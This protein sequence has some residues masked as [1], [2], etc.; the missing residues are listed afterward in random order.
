MAELKIA[1]LGDTPEPGASTLHLGRL[2]GP[3]LVRRALPYA[4]PQEE[5]PAA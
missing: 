3:L 4:L 1:A 2:D 5:T